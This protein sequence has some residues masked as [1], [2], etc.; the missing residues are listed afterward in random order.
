MRFPAVSYLITDPVGVVSIKLALMKNSPCAYN[1]P[2][3]NT[4]GVLIPE[5]IGVAT[6]CSALLIG[7]VLRNRFQIE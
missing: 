1:V 5:W 4:M 7:D 6:V 3:V 2:G